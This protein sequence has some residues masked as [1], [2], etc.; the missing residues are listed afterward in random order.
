L[1]QRWWRPP[2]PFLLTSE[3][4]EVVEVVEVVEASGDDGMTPLAFLRRELVP[5]APEES[6]KND[7]SYDLFA[8]LRDHNLREFL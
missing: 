8:V 5:V 1:S 6:T 4:E 7:T 3:D 2:P